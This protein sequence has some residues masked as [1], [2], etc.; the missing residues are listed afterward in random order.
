VDRRFEALRAHFP[1][2]DGDDLPATAAGELA[3]DEPVIW[4]GAPDRWGLFRATPFMVAVALAVGLSVYMSSGTGLTPTEYLWQLAGST[5]IDPRLMVAG[6]ALLFFGLLIASLRDPRDRWIYVATDRRLMTF[7]S[8]RRLRELTPD[9]L[10]RLRV[11]R[12]IEGRL[13][14]VGDV[15]WANNGSSEDSRSRGPDQGRHGFRGMR[16]PEA[17]LERLQQWG[18]AVEQIA[19]DDAREFSRGQRQA[20]SESPP[21]ARAVRLSNPR[22]G[23]SI[24]LPSRWAGRIGQDEKKPL[25]VLGLKLP[26]PSLD[27]VSNRPLHDPPADWNFI[28]VQGRSG[29]KFTLTVANEPPAATYEAVRARAG[30]SLVDAEGEVQLGPLRGFRVD[31]RH[32]DKVRIRRAILEGDGFHVQIIAALPNHQASDLLPAIDA[33]FGSIR[34]R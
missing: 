16:D 25:T 7:Y 26:I 29:M 10:R 27:R 17:W 9:R 21:A 32:R 14:N 34:A 20:D 30:D 3:R 1:K 15:V 19:S 4:H 13:H 31:Y 28:E 11:L 12:S 6:S 2:S 18:R 5:P 8:G 33:V 24:A 23:F 22:F